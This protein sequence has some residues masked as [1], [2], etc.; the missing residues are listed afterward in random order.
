MPENSLSDEEK[1]EMVAK[2]SRVEEDT[3]ETPE[4]EDVHAEVVDDI[5][6]DGN[7]WM[8]GLYMI[9]LALLFGVAEFV[10]VV[11]AVLQ[12]AWM[13]FAKERNAFLADTGQIIGN[14]LRQVSEFQTGAT[15]EKPFPWRHVS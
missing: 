5:E 14:W 10:L 6:Y 4:A 11:F 8:R 2:G 7:I 3:R 15:D 9:I 12:F 13:L 1:A